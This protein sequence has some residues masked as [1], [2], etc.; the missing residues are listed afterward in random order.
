M[1]LLNNTLERVF[2]ETNNILKKTNYITKDSFICIIK[3]I[4]FE[5]TPQNKLKSTINSNI[6]TFNAQINL[7]V[8]LFNYNKISFDVFIAELIAL[9]IE[10]LF[11]NDSNYSYLIFTI[12]NKL[13]LLN[14]RK[15]KN[16]IA[17]I[18]RYIKVINKKLNNKTLL[19]KIKPC[20]YYINKKRTTAKKTINIQENNKRFVKKLKITIKTIKNTFQKLIIA[21]IK[22]SCKIMKPIYTTLV[23][24]IIFPI[25]LQTNKEKFQKIENV[26]IK[27]IR[28]TLNNKI[29]IKTK[30][31]QK[32]IKSKDLDKYIFYKEQKK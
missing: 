8:R 28:T 4:V 30:N 11:D 17:E 14:Y 19:N 6:D 22:L 10:Y 1:E 24:N 3:T 32:H 21:V 27:H 13:V 7:V 23:K 2:Y 20:I 15:Y 16:K 9:I 25:E 26:G 31:K 18:N 29:F 5:I 12:N